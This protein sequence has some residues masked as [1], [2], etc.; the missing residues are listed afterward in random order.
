[1]L[2]RIHFLILLFAFSEIQAARIS[3][4]DSLS[5]PQTHSDSIQFLSNK[6][7]LD[8]L[9]SIAFSQDFSNKSIS[10]FFEKENAILAWKACL[11]DD[12]LRKFEMVL[13]KTGNYLNRNSSK[14]TF[15]KNEITIT[16]KHERGIFL[17][18]T[19]WADSLKNV[20]DPLSNSSG[21]KTLGI[22]PSS[23]KKIILD[24]MKEEAS[25]PQFVELILNSGS[26][27]PEKIEA[28]QGYT[29]Y[30]LVPKGSVGPSPFTPFWTKLEE[31]KT[32]INSELEQRFGL[33]VVS[34]SAKYDV[35]KIQLKDGKKANV[36]ESKIAE[37]TENGYKT[38][39]GAIQ[40]LVLDRSKWTI[41]V[42]EY[43]LE[44]FPIN[45]K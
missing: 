18:R 45:I 29:L 20:C 36:F 24:E 16:E 30:K 27:T 35:Y 4:T 10:F 5:Q 41:P 13:I 1:M 26:S 12:S 25:A 40:S 8:S 39:G 6:N 38:I 7:G 15:L 9:E 32:Y 23:V 33:P 17:E 43:N 31:L 14:F 3:L 2:K 42:L 37:T 22:E 21:F 34:I 11:A 44:I 28:K 19:W